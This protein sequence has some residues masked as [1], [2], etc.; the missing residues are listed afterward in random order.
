MRLSPIWQAGI[1]TKN[2]GRY[3]DGKNG[4]ARKAVCQDICEYNS[5]FQKLNIKDFSSINQ[6]FTLFFG[7][8]RKMSLEIRFFH[9]IRM[10][11]NDIMK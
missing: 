2:G 9:L 11:K 6:N 5:D 10:K 4:K 1:Q 3:A 8:L 7:V